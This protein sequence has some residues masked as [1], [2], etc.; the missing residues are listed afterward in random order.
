MGRGG[1]GR[2]GEERRK[3]RQLEA[4]HRVEGVRVVSK[5]FFIQ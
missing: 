3:R 4:K 5:R 2:R 1:E